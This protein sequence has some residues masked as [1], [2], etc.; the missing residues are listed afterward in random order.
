MKA[1]NL[2]VLLLFLVG[3]SPPLADDEVKE[4][5]GKTK[6]EWKLILTEKEY[7]ILWEGGTEAPFLGDLVKNN[8]TGTYVSAGCK[9]PVF[10][11]DQ[12]YDSGTGWPSFWGPI[13]EENIILREDNSYGWNRIEI[14]SKCGE[15]L[16]H[17]FNDGPQPT[18]KRYCLNS[19]AL[20][21]VED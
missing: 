21:F 20:D 1:I 14:L 8:K 6:E 2:L 9:I 15:H 18:G 5:S 19:A 16:G 7:R 13:N 11:S 10:S 3:C 4:L 12:K 17:V